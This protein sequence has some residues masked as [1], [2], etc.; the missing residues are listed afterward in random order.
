MPSLNS[1]SYLVLGDSQKRREKTAKLLKETGINIAKVS[2]DL[3]FIAP[4]KTKISIE[5]V[6]NLKSHI[7]QK[8]VSLPYKIIVIEEAEKLTVEAQNALLKILEEPPKSAVIILGAKEKSQLLP[9][10]LSRV[11]T[12]TT[13]TERGE[14]DQSIL[15]GSKN[16]LGLLEE[17]VA[18][19][20]PADWL[21]NQMLALYNT[22]Q[23]SA[24]EKRGVGE[25]ENAIRQ[26]ALAKQMIEAN[27]NPRHVLTDLILNLGN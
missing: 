16:T 22:L 14:G 25:I 12:I 21:D 6:R 4:E 26:C 9:T 17:I 10:I 13:E 8:P 20:N 27:V 1:Q 3:F 7:F 2:P 23:K 11:V 18:V 15:L 19:E 24:K 5:Q